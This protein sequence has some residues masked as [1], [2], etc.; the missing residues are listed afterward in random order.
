MKHDDY[1]VKIDTGKKAAIK[2]KEN[3]KLFISNKDFKSHFKV[4]LP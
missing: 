3:D 4:N 1:G 2:K